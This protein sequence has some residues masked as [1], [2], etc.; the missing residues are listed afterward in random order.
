M[1]LTR[2]TVKKVR[3]GGPRLTSG[4]TRYRAVLRDPETGAYLGG[5]ECWAAGP[6]CAYLLVEGLPAALAAALPRAAQ[7]AVTE[8]DSLLGVARAEAWRRRSPQEKP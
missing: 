7:R 1:K 4:L 8:G 2:V 5:L 6:V 3:E